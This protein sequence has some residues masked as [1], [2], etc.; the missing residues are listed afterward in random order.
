[1]YDKEK[2]ITLKV[3]DR[4]FGN[5]PDEINFMHIWYGRME[6]AQM[7]LMRAICSAIDNRENIG[8]YKPLSKQYETKKRRLSR[9][10][11]ELRHIEID[12]IELQEAKKKYGLEIKGC[13]VLSER[14]LEL[15][16]EKEQLQIEIVELEKYIPKWMDIKSLC[17]WS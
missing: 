15:K 1:M 14:E 10:N 6:K 5:L 4:R 17:W 16:K 12:L 9:I 7:L 13:N 11:S 8:T 2:N 3:P